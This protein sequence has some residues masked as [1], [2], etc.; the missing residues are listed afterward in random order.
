[1]ELLLRI[2]Y[3]LWGPF[4]VLFILLTGVYLTWRAGFVQLWCARGLLRQIRGGRKTGARQEITPLQAL[5]TSLGGTLGVGN[6]AGVA[7]ALTLGG[8]GAVFY[9]ILA[10]FFGMATKFS[11]IVLAVRFRIRQDGAPLGGPMVYLTRG[12]YHPGLA[13]LFCVCCLL[14]S[15]GTGAMTQAGAITQAVTAVVPLSPLLVGLVTAVAAWPV[16]TGGSRLIAKTA[17]VLVPFMTLF[18]LAGCA[19]VL[20]LGRE[21]IL[22]ALTLI[23]T[24]AARPAAAGGGLLGLLTARCV[25]DGFSKG[26]FS[27]EAGMG[28]APLAHGCADSKSPCEEGILGAV[29][30]FVDTCVVCLMTALVIL[31]SGAM[32]SGAQGLALT[33]L[34]FRGVLGDYAGIFICVTVCF[35]AFSTII[36]WSFYG[37][38]CLRYLVGSGRGAQ[39]YLTLITVSVALSALFPLDTMLLAADI[40]AALMAFPNLVGLWTLAPL[41]QLEVKKYQANKK[42]LE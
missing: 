7:A 20:F 33:T 39:L 12:A 29:E 38:T 17:S 19:I 23:L 10:A 24:D 37:L 41:V 25:S 27:N 14:A 2:R 8:P 5:F 9:M 4:T 16:L 11:E 15:I 3:A 31:V 22:P 6:L 1:M 35:L 32:D 21:R 30:V 36:G 40:A 13:K 26:V 34:A 28:S 42:R 18:Y